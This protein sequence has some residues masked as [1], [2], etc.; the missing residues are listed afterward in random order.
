M[1]VYK[2]NVLSN[3]FFCID[4]ETTGLDPNDPEAGIL[5]IYVK[6]MENDKEISN[7]HMLFY[8]PS[9]TRTADL[10][11]IA[12]EEIE[13]K[14]LFKDSEESKKYLKALFKRCA[15]PN[16]TFTFMAQ[17]SPFEHKWFKKFLDLSEEDKVWFDK[18]KTC[19]TH[20]ISKNLFPEESHA[21]IQMCEKYKIKFPEGQHDFHRA[22][23]DVNAMWEV[24]LKVRELIPEEEIEE[25]NPETYAFNFERNHDDENGE[26]N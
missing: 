11:K 5:E 22:D 12:L 2:N 1:K 18:V 4:I 23:Q 6:L 24:Y 9:W 15:D 8:H 26:N 16:D 14:P 3:S 10:H 21:L 25:Y 19:D 17:Y 20:W 13:G 7:R